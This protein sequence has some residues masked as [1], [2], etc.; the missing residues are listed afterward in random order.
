MQES[1]YE[2]HIVISSTAQQKADAVINAL[3]HI[4]IEKFRYFLRINNVPNCGQPCLIDPA[5]HDIESPMIVATFHGERNEI[6]RL[7]REGMSVLE[8]Q[9][10]LG[11][12]ELECDVLCD[13]MRHLTIDDFPGFIG[14]GNPPKCEVHVKWKGTILE[15]PSKQ[16]IIDWHTSQLEFPP[17]QITDLSS[18][19]NPEPNAVVSCVSTIY[20]AR[21]SEARELVRKISVIIGAALAPKDARAPIAVRGE[22]ICVVSEP[23]R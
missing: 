19:R 13:E 21:A 22:K 7:I 3:R 20:L 5:T 12:F 14:Q 10:M 11:N 8:G 9:G 23:T 1:P 2:A 16:K 4:G 15:L 6:I 17:N 18:Q